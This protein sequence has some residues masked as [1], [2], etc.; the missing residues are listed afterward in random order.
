MATRTEYGK[1]NRFRARRE[2]ASRAKGENESPRSQSSNI[3]SRKN[4]IDT[5]TKR[6]A[7]S[8]GTGDIKEE[9]QKAYNKF[10]A[11]PKK[12]ISS[13]KAFIS[14][15]KNENVARKT[16]EEKPRVPRKPVTAS[17]PT[18]NNKSGEEEE[19][20]PN[21]SK[22]KHIFDETIANEAIK[23]QQNLRKPR[24]ISEA[25]DRLKSEHVSDAAQGEIPGRPWSL[26]NYYKKTL[27]A[28]PAHKPHVSQ[29][30]AARRAMF[31]SGGSNEDVSRKEKR[32]PSLLDLVP[33]LKDL[34]INSLGND[35]SFAAPRS[36]TR[37][38]PG[39]KR[40]IYFIR[41]RKR[42]LSDTKTMNGEY[43]GTVGKLGHSHDD[44]VLRNPP[45]YTRRLY[46]SHSVDHIL[47]ISL[48]TSD[49]ESEKNAES[50][51]KQPVSSAN[52]QKEEKSTLSNK[53]DEVKATIK[54][55]DQNVTSPSV[56]TGLRFRRKEVPK[57]DFFDDTPGRIREASWKDEEIPQEESAQLE[58][59]P[60]SKYDF[61]TRPDSKAR[62]ESKIQESLS[63]PKHDSVYFHDHKKEEKEEAQ[64]PHEETESS[65]DESTGSVVE[66]SD[67]D[68]D[69]TH[70]QAISPVS[71]L[72]TAKPSSSALAA[73]DKEKKG[74]RTVEFAI[75]TP[76]LFP[77]YS[78]EE[79]D[80]AN[81]NIDPVTA[82][83][84]WE[85]EKRVEKMDVFSVDLGKGKLFNLM[86][87]SK[88]YPRFFIIH[89]AVL[90][91]TYLPTEGTVVQFNILQS[92]ATCIFMRK[93][94]DKLA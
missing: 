40:P 6:S 22:L 39:T 7:G 66:H 76:K 29:G 86:L 5:K 18:S 70:P 13:D 45:S 12:L 53:V 4:I 36:R 21:V 14:P 64:S 62:E 15:L 74:K 93:L 32:S 94:L 58:F 72:F 79:Y 68:E 90:H 34:D 84:E 37:S 75:E 92:H 87:C 24:P 25:L 89:N 65:G 52:N 61:T 73:K 28:T 77:T 31:E 19:S 63:H 17:E 41:S 91:F 71:L 42:F 27:P 85:L 47:Q 16:R 59:S 10:G 51:A 9:R 56:Q 11:P 8:P 80:R 54:S 20:K 30:I 78:A 88:S 44:S 83:A 2:V 57:D 3:A 55:D 81:D 60:S 23:A 1:E 38:D 33:D 50:T 82:S 48:P 46:K 26:P 67:V 35:E 69:H 43:H 49:S